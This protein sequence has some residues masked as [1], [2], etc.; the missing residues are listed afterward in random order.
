VV[1]TDLATRYGTTAPTRRRLLVAAVSLL[2]LVCLGWLVWVMLEHGDPEVTSELTGF[3]VVGEHAASAT[4]TVVRRT[5]EVEA[6]CLLRASASDHAVV[7]ELNVVVGPGDD[8]RQDLSETVRTERRATTVEMVGCR[9][10]GQNRR[11]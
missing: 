1:V 9:A 6:S 2:V 11:R 3:E 7:G 10:E 8:E 5:P 4:F